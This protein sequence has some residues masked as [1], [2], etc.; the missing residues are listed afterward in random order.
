MSHSPAPW[1]KD[2]ASCCRWGEDS[3]ETLQGKPPSAAC[4]NER[5]GRTCVY[6]YIW[7]YIYINIYRYKVYRRIF[8]C[9]TMPRSS[10]TNFDC[11]ARF[12]AN[13]WLSRARHPEDFFFPPPLFLLG[14]SGG[15][16]LWHQYRL[17]PGE[18]DRLPSQQSFFFF[19]YLL[20]SGKHFILFNIVNKVFCGGG[21][22]VYMWHS[23]RKKVWGH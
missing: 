19:F 1:C 8:E 10:C 16:F 13:T 7:H 15:C 21:S 22:F 11:F 3:A 9:G 6:I 5:L 4:A 20:F 23:V 18:C 14:R 17:G 12:W 2:W